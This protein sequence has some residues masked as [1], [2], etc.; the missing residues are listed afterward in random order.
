MKWI[1]FYSYY[2]FTLERERERAR[3][4]KRVRG[5]ERKNLKQ[6]WHELK[7]RVR[8]STDWTTNPCKMDFLLFKFL[9]FIY[10][11]E[12]GRDRAQAKEGQS[13]RDTQD[14]K[15][16]QALSCQHGAWCVARTHKHEIMTWAEFGCSADWATQAPHR[17]PFKTK[18]IS[19]HYLCLRPSGTI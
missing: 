9:T 5:Q 3:A 10:F 18:N 15:Q 16:L 11:W 8:F 6:A 19:C 7:S 17:F 1:S 4:V 13:E 2:Y 12:R 14:P